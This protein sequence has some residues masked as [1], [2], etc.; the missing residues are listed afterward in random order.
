MG[1]SILVPDKVALVCPPSARY[2]T[3]VAGAAAK[4]CEIEPTADLM[5]AAATG[6]KR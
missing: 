2:R 6:E 4:L 3:P 1:N 5:V